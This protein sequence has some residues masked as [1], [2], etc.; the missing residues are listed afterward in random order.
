MCV[1]MCVKSLQ[2]CLIL[3]PSGLWP[4]R[5]LCP[6]DPPGQNTGGGCHALLQG[7][8]LTHG[9]NLSLLRFL[10]WQ[11][12]SLPWEAPVI[13]VTI[14]KTE[15]N[16]CDTL[17]ARHSPE[18]LTYAAPWVLLMV[19]VRGSDTHEQV[20]RWAQKYC[21]LLKLTQTVRGDPRIKF[22]GEF[23]AV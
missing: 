8:P 9:L 2:L 16:I 19:C 22:P 13:I 10:H 17:P 6:W 20:P 23:T 5:L 7:I 15:L 12:D 4:T 14:A 1:C 18:C 11:A 3:R 21:G